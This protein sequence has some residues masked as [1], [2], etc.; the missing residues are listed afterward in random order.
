MSPEP[1][2]LTLFKGSLPAKP[3]CTDELTSGL[4]IRDV[5]SAITRR[6]IQPNH[7]NSRLWL[8]YDVDRPTCVSELTDELLLPAP[9]FFVQNRDN[10]HAHAYYGLETAVHMNLGSS[11]AALRFA[12]AVDCALTCQMA[13]DGQYSGLIAKNPSHEHWR[14]Y[15]INSESY[16]LGEL[17][18]YLDLEKYGDKRRAY[19]E[20]GIGRNVNLFDR[21]RRWAYKAIRQGWPKEQQWHRAVFERANMYNV[22]DNPLPTNEVRHIA[23]SVSKWVFRNFSAQSF[24]ETQAA[25][26]ARKG[27]KRRDALLPKAMK[28]RA[29]G[30]SERAIA[31]AL[32]VSQKTINNWLNEN[33][34]YLSKSHIR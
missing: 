10:Q 29:Q 6:Y 26:G 1:H 34:S 2:Q 4:L 13:A 31:T 22:H 27:K 11:Q 3:Y 14:T 28:M 23:V 7:P 16:E 19:P 5:R 20:S 9:H 25:R 18:E 30:T 12:A 8:V 21:L 24:S 17:A 33:N 32:G 15:I